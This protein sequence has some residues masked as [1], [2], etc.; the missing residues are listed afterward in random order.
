MYP[1]SYRQFSLDENEINY[2]EKTIDSIDT[3]ALSSAVKGYSQEQLAL[4]NENLDSYAKGFLK[5]GVRY[6]LERSLSMEKMGIAED[7][8]YYDIVKTAVDSL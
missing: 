3:D 8:F 5:A 6:R 7:E 4:M 1:L 2:S